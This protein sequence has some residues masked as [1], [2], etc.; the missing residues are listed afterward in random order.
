M[1][2]D[3]VVQQ[4]ALVD[5]QLRMMRAGMSPPHF[6]AGVEALNFIIEESGSVLLDLLDAGCA[7]GY[8]WEVFEHF[9]P[10]MVD[11]HGSDFN[12][13]MVRAAKTFY[14]GVE[15][16][17]W[18]LRQPSR[19]REYQVVFSGATLMHIREWR[20]ALRNLANASSEWL[21]LHRT[22]LKTDGSGTKISTGDAYSH[23][24]WYIT[25]DP[26]E[27]VEIL[28]EEG[29]EKKI[30]FDCGEGGGVD[31]MVKTLVFRRVI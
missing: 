8:Y 15:F 28:E 14:P 5:N 23:C 26:F 16:V 25:F 6:A 1:N 11:Y 10:G 2:E 12:P 18:D 20:M 29:F 7:S 31:W 27:L 21:V 19:T 22:W 4:R 17:Q 9:I 30:G 3:G 13:A 24:A